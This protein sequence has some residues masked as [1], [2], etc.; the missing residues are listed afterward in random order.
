MYSDVFWAL[1]F[2]QIA[3]GAFDTLYHHELTLRLAWQPQQAKELRLHG[4]RNLLYAVVFLTLAWAEPRGAWAWLLITVL[5]TE[6]AITLADFVEE[7]RVRKLPAS[8]RITHT[9]LTLNYGVLLALWLP[10]LWQSAHA[11]SALMA[12]SHHWWISGLLTLSAFGV[13]VFGVRDLFAA[14][15]NA[16]LADGDAAALAQALPNDRPQSILITGGT[17]FIGSR[18]TAA[19]CAAGHDVTILTRNAKAA[20]HLALSGGVSPRFITHLDQIPSNFAVDAIVNLAGEPIANA[21][22]TN[23]KR[24]RIIAS[25]IDTTRDINAL[26]ARLTQTPGVV[27]NGS[28]IGIYGVR[29]ED[30]SCDE[31]TAP[32][33]GFAATV[34]KQWEAEAMRAEALGVRVVRLRTGLV[35]GRSGGMLAN[36]LF[37]FE[38][39]AGTVLGNG[40]QI[41]SWIHRD[42]VV[43]MICF[44]IATPAIRGAL[45]ATAPAPCT[46]RAFANAL[47]RALHRPV[48]LAVPA[49][50]LGWV[51][52]DLAKELLLGGQ[53]VLPALALAHGFRFSFGNIDDAL[54]DC[55]GTSRETAHVT[56]T[57]K[58]AALPRP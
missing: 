34:C 29:S 24:A 9:L 33:G 55:V 53:R 10:H 56:A 12:A 42:D 31:T 2:V 4:V 16:R 36:L 15:R 40:K 51:A 27:I 49:A 20:T 35:L 41:M 1:L 57:E 30:E 21:L 54:R 48:F 45:N 23:A 47:G 5:I 28:A 14:A 26:L 22:W 38:F 7:D 39:G 37:S 32:G 44:A 8:E 25:R 19:L 6:L 50:P 17:G 58:L 43:R 52:G 18:L 13:G 3:M 46:Q 11:P